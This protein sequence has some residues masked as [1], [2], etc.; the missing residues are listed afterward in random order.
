MYAFHNSNKVFQQIYLQQHLL[1]NN[2]FQKK[3]LDSIGVCDSV[4]L[5]T[6]MFPLSD[7]AIM[8]TDY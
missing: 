2:F 1:L 7:M 4:K 3:L 6:Y 8:V 5:I